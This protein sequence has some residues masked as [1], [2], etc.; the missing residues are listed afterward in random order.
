MTRSPARTGTSMA[1][2]AMLC[3]QLGLAASV[4]LIDDIGT[5]GAA[6][7]RLFWAGILLL[8]IVRPRLRDYSREALVAGTAL[9][10]VTAGVTVLF[11]G[12][13]ARLPL[14]TA[15]ALEFLGPLTIAVVRSR[16]AGRAWALLA[17]AGVLCLTQPW[18]G[19][20]DPVGVALA[21]GAAVCWAAY[22]LLTQRVGDAVSGL[23]GLA[24]SMP[25]AALVST[26][27]AGPGVVGH[28]TPGLLLYGL[29]LAILLPVVPFALELMALRRLT[30][31][32]FGTLM[33]LE[34]AFALAVGFLALAQVPDGLGVAGIVLVVAAGMGAERSGS[35][36]DALVHPV[37][38]E[39]RPPVDVVP[40]WSDELEARGGDDH[41]VAG[42]GVQ[43]EDRLGHGGVRPQQ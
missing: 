27:V 16:G 11:M 9:G 17:A 26:V 14:G 28:L 5:S 34:P 12:A 37:G 15:S 40:A 31:G 29:G 23:G 21:L 10:V 33:A 35:R 36:S 43:S 2:A 8:V 38:L 39:D 25:V 30:T 24:I 41:P 6:W 13:V 32:A 18:T 19:D 20:A 3:V 4:G 1:V 7:L 22:I 42:R